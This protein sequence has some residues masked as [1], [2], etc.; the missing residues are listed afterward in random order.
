[1]TVYQQLVEVCSYS[2]GELLTAIEIKKRVVERFGT[3]PSSILPSDY[4]YNRWNQGI[5]LRNPLFVR[6]GAGEYRYIGPDQPYTG[7]VFWRPKNAAADQVVGE[8][9]NGGLS[10]YESDT[11]PVGEASD[12]TES[13]SPRI[14]FGGAVGSEGI[15]LSPKQLD[16]LY[17]EYMEFY[18]AR[19][20]RAQ[21]A[22]RVNQEGFDV[23]AG[24]GRRISVKTTAQR[25]GFVSV[26]ANT[27]ERAD[28][29]MVLRYNDGDFEVVYHGEVAP[30]LRAARLWEGRFEL[31]LTKA[32]KLTASRPLG[33]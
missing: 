9:V 16:R 25:A 17:E 19:V 12:E 29:L 15:P 1:M 8:W 6:V 2:A 10:I 7:L 5:Q 30:A 11:T 14:D 13:E 32:R 22:R 27:V 28:D 24:T 4:S 33:T 18:C 20:T 21:L 3:N 23:V 31:D 26:N